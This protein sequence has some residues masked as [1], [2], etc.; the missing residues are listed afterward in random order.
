MKKIDLEVKVG[1][2]SKKVSKTS[3]KKIKQNKTKPNQKKKR[4]FVYRLFSVVAR[5]ENRKCTNKIVQKKDH[6]IGRK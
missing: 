6:K 2:S 1:K 4:E 3:V 5:V